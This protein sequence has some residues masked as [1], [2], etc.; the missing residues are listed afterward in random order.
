MTERE[1]AA[2]ISALQETL[3]AVEGDLSKATIALSGSAAEEIFA[4]A[5]EPSSIKSRLTDLEQEIAL[6]PS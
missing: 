1:I 2:H 4:K 3:N 5:S 6:L